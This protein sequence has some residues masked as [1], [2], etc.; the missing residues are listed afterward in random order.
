[1]A[2][3]G[4][5]KIARNV[6]AIFFIVGLSL[7]SFIWSD[8]AWPFAP[9]RQFAW[10]PKDYVWSLALDAELADG[11]VVRIPYERFHLRRAEAEGQMNR[12]A[13]NPRMLGD[14]MDD[15]NKKVAPARRIIALTAIKRETPVVNGRPART[16]AEVSRRDGRGPPPGLIAQLEIIAR[17]PPSK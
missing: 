1:M 17:W 14:L 2:M 12:L 6:F 16:A 8:D 3:A 9:M 15:Y 4:R 5:S 13:D 11:R 7:G 10:S